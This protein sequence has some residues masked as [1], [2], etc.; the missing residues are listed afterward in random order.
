MK[1]IVSK[2]LL[3]AGNDTVYRAWSDPGHLKNWWGPHGF[4][5]TFT[6]FDLRPGGKWSLVMHGPDGKDYQSEIIFEDIV[7]GVMLAFSYVIN[8]KIRVEAIFEAITQSKTLVC[9]KMIFYNEEEFANLKN[10]M[11]E[12]NEENLDRLENELSKMKLLYAHE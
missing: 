10:F 12:K 4:T 9:F 11:A 7:P 5:N 8:H 3:D 1:E 2:R 6:E